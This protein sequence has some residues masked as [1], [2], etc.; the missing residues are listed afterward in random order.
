MLR[1]KFNQKMLRKPFIPLRRSVN[2]LA[3]L[4]G[5]YEHVSWGLFYTK[6]SLVWVYVCVCA[7]ARMHAHH[8]VIQLERDRDE[9]LLAK[10]FL[11]GCPACISKWKNIGSNHMRS[12]SDLKFLLKV[13]E[14][15]KQPNSKW[16]KITS[17]VIMKK[18]IR[19]PTKSCQALIFSSEQRHAAYA[20]GSPILYTMWRRWERRSCEVPSGLGELCPYYSPWQC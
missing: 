3:S 1:Q 4:A 10:V 7:C 11:L 12:K 5:I 8:L 20:V 13:N 19:M 16:A 18:D 6:R 14:S 17:R 15:E 9:H 2:V